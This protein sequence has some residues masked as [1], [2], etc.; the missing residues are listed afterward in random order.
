[1]LSAGTIVALI[2]VGASAMYGLVLFGFAK[3]RRRMPLSWF[4]LSC[5]MMGTYSVAMV[6]VTV[7]NASEFII[8][9]CAA[10]G[11]MAAALFTVSATRYIYHR[12]GKL[13]STRT[14]LLEIS[15]ICVAAIAFIPGV[16]F[17]PEELRQ[18]EFLNTTYR[19]PHATRMLAA[20]AV[21]IIIGFANLVRVTAMLSPKSLLFGCICLVLAGGNDIAISNHLYESSFAAAAGALV[22]LL[23]LAWD[24]ASQWGDEAKQLSDLK[25]TL[26]QRVQERSNELAKTLSKLARSERLAALGRMSASIGH[27]LNNPLTYVMLNLELLKDE[28][29]LEDTAALEHATEGAERIAGIVSQLR[30]L[31]KPA[32]RTDEIVDIDD[33]LQTAARTVKHKTN[34]L[35]R[36][37][38]H[39]Q[40][41][42]A[43][44]VGD[45]LRMIQLFVN[46]FSNSIEALVDDGSVQHV[47]V[48]A[49]LV[50]AKVIVKV[51]D[52][53][54]GIPAEIRDRLFE[55]FATGRSDG[56]G[57]GLAIV[58]TI[59]DEV[60]G[61]ILVES[62][63]REGSTFTVEF[64]H[65][66][67]VQSDSNAESRFEHPQASVIRVLIVDDEVGLTRSLE[68]LLP[69]F[70]V[71]TCSSGEQAVEILRSRE[72]DI[73]VCDLVMPGLSGLEVFQKVLTEQ[74]K[75][76]G[77]FVLMSGGIPSEEMRRTLAERNTSYLSKP[78]RP[79]E[80]RN[81]IVKTFASTNREIGNRH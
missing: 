73:V 11:Y 30:V 78:F 21:V 60:D 56:L 62:T 74:P 51:I 1:M 75:Y 13:Y 2:L 3:A 40:P 32:D 50:A 24:E 29:R 25:A 19:F 12:A 55:P 10:I 52:E 48:Q 5:L 15:L 70:E 49:S 79:A 23:A 76:Q 58:Q 77:R 4:A 47:R 18:W 65:A 63:V 43:F 20:A 39:S 14:R 67:P 37:E 28:P 72:F 81:I 22:F 36:L 69:E 27:E 45:R 9:L 64:P 61:T 34:E 68:R 41:N 17:S 6:L 80:L 66:E 53:G 57:L 44:V 7:A 38:V 16:L 59:V 46:L 31:S 42:Q 26:E 71:K 35:K 33:V 54:A 8:R